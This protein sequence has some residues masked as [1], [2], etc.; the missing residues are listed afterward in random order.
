[1]DEG[2]VR[3]VGVL[4]VGTIGAGIVQL[5]AQTG[6]GVIA[7]DSNVEAL[8]KAQRYVREGLA[9]FADRGEFSEE[10]AGEHY[11]CI[12]WTV[13][14]EE[15]AEAGAAI[16]AIVEKVRPKKEA[17]TAL[18]EIL[19]PDALLLTNTSSISI[20]D[21][22]SATSRPE[23]VCGTHFFTPPPIR[24]AVEVPRGLLTSDETVERVKA[25]I[26][27]FGK[28]PVVLEKDVPGFVANQFLMPM[29]VEAA[30]LLEEGSR[31]RRR[32][33]CW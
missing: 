31:A 8:E 27:S 17:F 10:E 32:L 14:P 5:A 20:T 24:E 22:A 29:L 13:N 21:L 30:R 3:T 16:E 6:H 28:V 25:L 26:N 12:H 23:R 7:C 11:D 18:D 4:G 19:P 9:R 33:T 1:M 2:G 15:M